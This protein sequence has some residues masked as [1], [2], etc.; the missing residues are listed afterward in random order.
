MGY[1]DANN[2]LRSLS[3]KVA[4]DTK[5]IGAFRTTAQAN[6]DGY[7]QLTW[8][9]LTALQVLYLVMFKN[10][11]SQAALGQGYT[12]NSTEYHNTGVLDA[13]GMNHGTDSGA[14]ANDAVK[15][16][17][18]EDFFG[19]KFQWVDG[20]INGTNLIKIADG[21]FNDTGEGYTEHEGKDRKS[22][23]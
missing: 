18:I 6:G 8:N 20:Y 16:C 3:G 17:G 14:T 2:K 1:V 23:V 19:N 4:A 7:E 21:N 11:N 10:L 12:N 9:K 15:F 13:K 5:T 22:V